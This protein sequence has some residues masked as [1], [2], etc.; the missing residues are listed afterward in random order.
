[1]PIFSSTHKYT[2]LACVHYVTRTV[3]DDDLCTCSN[4][5]GRQHP[6]AAANIQLY[7]NIPVA[8]LATLARSG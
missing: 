3:L 1:M 7:T 4:A 6:I 2:S 5:H 8:Y